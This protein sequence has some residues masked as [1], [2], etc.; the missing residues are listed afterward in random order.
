MTDPNHVNG[1]DISRYAPPP[2]AEIVT[3]QTAFIAKHL[4]LISVHNIDEFI[5]ERAPT[6]PLTGWMFLGAADHFLI[7]NDGV[8]LMM[9]LCQQ[10]SMY[11]TLGEGA[12]LHNPGNVGDMDD[13]STVDFGTWENGVWAVAEWLQ[14]HRV[15]AIGEETM[16][17]LELSN[18]GTEPAGETH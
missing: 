14:R 15:P 13:G 9:A 4:P 16:T 3:K 10:D 7:D 11:G 2:H 17:C 18:E 8:R 5:Y 6:S 1:F 12:R